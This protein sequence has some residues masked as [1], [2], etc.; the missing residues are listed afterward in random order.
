[1]AVAKDKRRIK[2]TVPLAVFDVL[3]ADAEKNRTSLSEEASSHIT[4][5]L[6]QDGRL[7]NQK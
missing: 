1:M 3:M 6:K 2:V 7:Q 4:R 5:S